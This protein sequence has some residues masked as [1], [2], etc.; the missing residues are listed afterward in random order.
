MAFSMAMPTD[1]PSA[2]Q[3]LSKMF[4][5]MEPPKEADVDI[6]RT[7]RIT[8]KCME[9][10]FNVMAYITYQPEDI[11]YVSEPR[12]K[13]PRRSQ[14][15]KTQLSTYVVGETIVRNFIRQ[16]TRYENAPQDD[17]EHGHHR[18]ARPHVVSAYW[19]KQHYGPKNSLTKMIWVPSFMRCVNSDEDVEQ[20]PLTVVNVKG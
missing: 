1:M 3:M 13:R 17:D 15:N 11:V 6:D 5:V 8:R 2:G 19:R 18:T 20:I 16:R 9:I 10:A 4:D 12:K 14:R 7:R